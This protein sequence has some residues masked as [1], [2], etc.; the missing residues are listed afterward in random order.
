MEASSGNFPVHR[1]WI[2]TFLGGVCLPRDFISHGSLHVDYLCR[3]PIALRDAI[4]R[5]RSCACAVL[6]LA[7]DW[8]AADQCHRLG[9]WRRHGT[10]LMAAAARRSAKRS[11]LGGTVVWDRGGSDPRLGLICRRCRLGGCLSCFTRSWTVPGEGIL[12]LVQ[13]RAVLPQLLAS[14]RAKRGGWTR[15]K[16]GLWECGSR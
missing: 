14:F 10:H 7:S 13:C 1:G 5:A 3:D 4:R 2:C 9:S 12:H 11:L 16:V 15:T 6:S 8:V